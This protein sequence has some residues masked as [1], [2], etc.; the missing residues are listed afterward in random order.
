MKKALS[1]FVSLAV[2]ATGLVLV[3]ASTASASLGC[4]A[5]SVRVNSTS[6]G[7]S[8]SDQNGHSH[9]TGK[10]YLKTITSSKMWYWSADNDNGR[11]DNWDTAYGFTQ[12]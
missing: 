5:T 7:E 9:V 1:T 3:P 11:T 8:P 2:L 6:G 12:C 10:H 4:S